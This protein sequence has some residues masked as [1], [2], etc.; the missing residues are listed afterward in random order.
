MDPCRIWKVTEISAFKS[1]TSSRHLLSFFPLPLFIIFRPSFLS[2]T[3]TLLLIS[4]PF[5]PPP[6]RLQYPPPLSPSVSAWLS[7]VWGALSLLLSL[8][9]SHSCGGRGCFTER[10]NGKMTGET[11]LMTQHTNTQMFVKMKLDTSECTQLC[12]L[13]CGT[14]RRVDILSYILCVLMLVPYILIS[15]WT[16]AREYSF[17]DTLSADH[18]TA[19]CL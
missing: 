6:Q 11:W 4:F 1:F 2:L 15:L 5:L 9:G 8:H 14:Q 10:V 19:D 3:L 18:H 12:V 16:T 13:L 17:K 7:L